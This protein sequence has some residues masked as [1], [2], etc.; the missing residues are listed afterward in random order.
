MSALGGAEMMMMMMMCWGC[1]LSSYEL[2]VALSLLGE[3]EEEE[4]EEE[5]VKFIPERPGGS[6][7]V[8]CPLKLFLHTGHVSCCSSQGT[9][10]SL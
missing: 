5:G 4:E 9:I 6:M 10:Q 3:L 8:F 7:A 1:G 2:L